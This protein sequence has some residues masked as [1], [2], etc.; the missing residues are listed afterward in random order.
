M[1]K[2]KP[3]V[4]AKWAMTMD[5]RI[6]TKMDSKW[7]TGDVARNHVHCLRNSVDAILVGANTAL[8]DNPSLNVRCENLPIIRQALKFVLGGNNLSI[9]SNIFTIS[10][11]K[12]Y[13]ICEN[14]SEYANS[15]IL[16]A[17][18]VNF[19]YIKKLENGDFD[20]HE[21][22][23]KMADLSVTSLLVEGG[24]YTLAKF[25]QADLINKFYCYMAPKFIAGSESI[26]PFNQ[27]IGINHIK[28]AKQAKFTNIEMLGEDILLQGNF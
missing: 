22:L 2:K 28:N 9:D 8:K 26:A 17:R 21:L 13:I 24:G 6:S 4:I 12:T 15:S 19:I 5:G 27:D 10:P 16:Q 11:E 7:I 1:Q 25:L 18:G 14:K 23:S 3:F 20:L